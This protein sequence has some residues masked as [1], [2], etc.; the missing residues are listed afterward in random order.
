VVDVVEPWLF[1]L[2]A[3]MTVLPAL[4]LL[5]ARKPVHIAAG[6]VLAM[7]GLAIAYVALEAP[8]LGVVQV[9]VY[10]GAVMMLFLFVLMLVGVDQ[11]ENLKENIKNQR[12]IGFSLAIGIA[13]MLISVLSRTSLLLNDKPADSD[14]QDIAALLFGRYVIVVEALAL[15]C[16][17]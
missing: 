11:R 4:S 3:A 14:P 2:I 9:V 7:V 6:I 17:T 10:T 13:A 15:S 1:W 16:G 8:F 12:W 5:F